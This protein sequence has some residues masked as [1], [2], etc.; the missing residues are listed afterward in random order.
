MYDSTFTPVSR[1]EAKLMALVTAPFLI[2]L[3]YVLAFRIRLPLEGVF[4]VVLAGLFS[5]IMFPLSLLTIYLAK[6]E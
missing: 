3:I 4:V 2:A 1:T 5:A 6:E